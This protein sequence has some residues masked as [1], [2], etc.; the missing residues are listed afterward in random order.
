[1]SKPLETT[2]VKLELY[3]PFIWGEIEL[4]RNTQVEGWLVFDVPKG[5]IL[6]SLWWEEIDSMV[7]DYIDYYRGRR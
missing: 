4:G 5:L 3:S 1:M 6:G 2:T 7:V